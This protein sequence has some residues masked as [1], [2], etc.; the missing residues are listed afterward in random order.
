MGGVPPPI[1]RDGAQ[2]AGE[3][4][5]ATTKSSIFAVGRQIAEDILQRRDRMTRHRRLTRQR[6]SQP[7]ASD[8]FGE[9][10]CL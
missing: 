5:G 6:R 8:C 4:A 3:D 7:S 1:R 9:D 2:T 10:A